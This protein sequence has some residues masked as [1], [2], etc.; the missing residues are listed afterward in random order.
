MLLER[1]AECV[2]LHLNGHLNGRLHL[3]LHAPP[4][5]LHVCLHLHLWLHLC[6][7]PHDTGVCLS[8]SN[9]SARGIS[10]S[11]LLP[12]FL[13]FLIQPLTYTSLFCEKG[14]TD[15]KVYTDPAQCWGWKTWGLMY[16]NSRPSVKLPSSRQ[17]SIDDRTSAAINGTELRVLIQTQK[18]Q[19][20]DH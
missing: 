6:W 10:L 4:P 5:H 8:V 3:R 13:S 7:T 1:R 19:A 9:S 11:F 20:M 12:F 17:K 18:I 2:G 16:P 14:Q 15:F